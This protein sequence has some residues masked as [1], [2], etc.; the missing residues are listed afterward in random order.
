MT[1]FQPYAT[2]ENYI[3]RRLLLLLAALA[4]I[5]IAILLSVS[6]STILSGMGGGTQEIVRTRAFEILNNR[7]QPVLVATSDQLQNGVLW[8]GAPNGQGGVSLN[9]DAS[10]NGFF[11]VNTATSVPLVSAVT[12][13]L[14]GG[15]LQVYSAQGEQLA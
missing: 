9:T 8:V 10:G 15:A 7:G 12:S 2:L 11:V 13:D 1:A 4:L 3:G 6:M 14:D 5:D